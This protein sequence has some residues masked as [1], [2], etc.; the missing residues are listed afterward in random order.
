MERPGSKENT[1]VCRNC[2]GDK[3]RGRAGQ[4]SNAESEGTSISTCL[5]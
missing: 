5:N 4:V 1:L 3:V 2:S